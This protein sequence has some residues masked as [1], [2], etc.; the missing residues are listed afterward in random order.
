MRVVDRARL[1]I[2]RADLARRNR[3]IRDLRQSEV[4]NLGMSALGNEDVR[5]FDVA[6]DDAFGMRGIKGI[7]NLDAERE[8]QFRV[9]RAIADAVL[10]GHAVEILHGD[11]VLPTALINLEHHADIWVVQ[12]RRRLGLALEAGE[13]LRVLGY[14][15]GQELQGNKAMQLDVLGFVDH[16]HPPAAEFFD[17]A[18]VGDGLV[19]HERHRRLRGAP[20][21][22]TT[23]GEVNK[24][25]GVWLHRER[26]AP[27]SQGT[28]T[29]RKA[30]GSRT[31]KPNSVCGIAPAGRSFLWATH[32]CGAQATY[33]E[34]VT[35]RAGT[36]SQTKL[37][38]HPSP[39]LFGLA[40]CGVCPARC[41]TAAAV[42]SY[43]TFSPLPRRC[44]RG[45]MFSVALA[46]NRA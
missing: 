5:R 21:V 26:V 2:R 24:N 9:H 43:R 36:F 40:P 17:N 4:Q 31:C 10:Q 32:Y 38:P 8:N 22:M 20:I 12:R 7:R 41:I 35:R 27:P 30:C 29:G 34:V 33:P 19:D 3:W 45:G 37:S 25:S 16:T 46:V 11:E 6:V 13:R 18:I 14:F 42:R 44:R 39:S 1:R 28:F 15:I 23:D